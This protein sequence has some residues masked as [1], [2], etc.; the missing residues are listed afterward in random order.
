MSEK[1]FH[2]IETFEIPKGN[3]EFDGPEG[4]VQGLDGKIYVGSGDG[5]IYTLSK[6]G[7]VKPYVEVGGRPLGLAIDREDNL[8]VCDMKRSAIVRVSP[9]LRTSVVADQA[10]QRRMKLPNFG[11]FDDR[12]EFYVSDSGSSTLD[13]PR[14]DGG[15][16]RISPSGE[17][18][19][20]ADGLILPNGL[21][22]RQ[23]E[24]ALYIAQSTENNV[25]RMDIG[26]D[27]N[28]TSVKVYAEGLDKI[29]RPASFD[30]RSNT[31]KRLVEIHNADF[32]SGC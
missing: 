14:P 10:E 11:V 6:S 18:N 26:P 15:I 9:D 16:F 21:A 27:N 31:I 32:E 5:W 19:L 30:E 7:V 4:I 12:G 1:K 23:G 3:D 22:I 29:P 25:L 28:P 2:S 8:L 24:S 17:C 13:N 20:V